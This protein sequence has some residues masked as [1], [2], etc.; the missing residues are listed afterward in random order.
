MTKNKRLFFNAYIDT[1]PYQGYIDKVPN[2]QSFR[3]KILG[4]IKMKLGHLK[5]VF[6]YVIL[7][8]KFSKHA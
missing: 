3:Y 6:L 1:T 7:L 2:K 4:F 5:F 8:N